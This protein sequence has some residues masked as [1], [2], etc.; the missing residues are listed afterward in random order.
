MKNRI[1]AVAIFFGLGLLALGTPAPA[2]DPTDAQWNEMFQVM[3]GLPRHNKDSRLARLKTLIDQGADVNMAIGFDRMLRVG[4]TYAD[5]RPT[6]WPL[7][8]A[9]QQAE[10]E[11]VKLLLAKG[12]KLHGK[13]LV[14]AAFARNADESLA[15]LKAL[16]DAGA[17]VNATDDDYKFTALFWASFRGNKKSVELLL[18]QP[19]IKLDE[20]DVDGGT[21][22]MA[23]ARN[24]HAE[25]MEMLLDAGANAAIADDG[26]ETATSLAKK[27]FAKQQEIVEKE[28]ALL[29]KQK[30]IIS[31]LEG[32]HTKT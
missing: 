25:I 20:T 4:E 30:V 31:K 12:A 7:D 24:G 19:G 22:L 3:Y 23:A 2:A 17:D 13:E 10:V 21:A 16:L 8:V 14:N 29:R 1:P 15:M 28:K 9:A 18:A 32:R 26:G 6:N 5:L 11:M 27:A